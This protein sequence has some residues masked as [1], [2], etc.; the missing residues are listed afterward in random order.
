MKIILM[1]LLCTS[2]TLSQELESEYEIIPPDETEW[3]I[4]SDMEAALL[5][6]ALRYWDEYRDSCY[7]DSTLHERKSNL[8][9]IMGWSS[10]FLDSLGVGEDIE[11]YVWM[12]KGNTIFIMPKYYYTHRDPTPSSFMEFLR[13]RK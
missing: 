2:L 11:D 5:H 9:T 1:L 3:R 6:M 4:G 13:R 7:A 10:L 12:R 8:S